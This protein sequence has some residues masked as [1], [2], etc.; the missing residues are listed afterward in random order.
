MRSKKLPNIKTYS[1]IDHKAYVYYKDNSEIVTR[2]LVEHYVE[3]GKLM[4]CFYNIVEEHLADNLSGV[5]LDDIGYFGVCKYQDPPKF[6]PWYLWQEAKLNISECFYMMYV[7]ISVHIIDRIYTM[8]TSFTKRVR[9][10]LTKRVKEGFEYMFNPSAF[11]YKLRT[12]DK[13]RI[14][15]RDTYGTEKIRR[16]WTNRL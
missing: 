9:G 1:T 4:T 11:Y 10:L 16:E 2:K 12:H 6:R 13:K 7:P 5:Y 14:N 3:Y 15:G 8:D